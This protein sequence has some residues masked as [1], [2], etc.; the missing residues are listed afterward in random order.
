MGN[1]YRG[2]MVLQSE[3]DAA[4]E[5]RDAEIR[6]LRKSRAALRKAL[7]E[8]RADLAHNSRENIAGGIRAAL[9]RDTKLAR[10]GRE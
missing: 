9:A 5:K 8:A 6:M 4:I 10:K 1:G 7:R 3:A 2:A